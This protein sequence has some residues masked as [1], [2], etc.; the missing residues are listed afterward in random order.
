MEQS[1][2]YLFI[3]ECVRFAELGPGAARL[4]MARTVPAKWLAKPV[5]VVMLLLMAFVSAH[6][7]RAAWRSLKVGLPCRSWRVPLVPQRQLT[8]LELLEEEKVDQRVED[9]HR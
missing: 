8:L 7:A 3:G 2:S 9:I 5:V 1:G 6:L 4:S